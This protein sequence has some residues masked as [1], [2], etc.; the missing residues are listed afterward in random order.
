MSQLLGLGLAVFRDKYLGSVEIFLALAHRSPD[1]LSFQKD[2]VRK[3]H[4]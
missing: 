2:R 4:R 1:S 3:K